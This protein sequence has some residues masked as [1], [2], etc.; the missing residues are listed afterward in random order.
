MSL[1]DRIARAFR[2]ELTTLG[3]LRAKAAP[4]YG[5]RGG[6]WLGWDPAPLPAS[7]A[8]V[9]TEYSSVVMACV[10]SITQV[11]AEA[12]VRVMRQT[13]RGVV[14]EMPGHALSALV[15]RPNPAFTSFEQWASLL[16]DYTLAG[17]A[18]LY[19][20]RNRYA[21]PVELWPLPTES[22]EAHWPKEGDPFISHYVF[23]SGSKRIRLAAEDVLHFRNAR[24]GL[25]WRA[26]REGRY[27]RS[28]LA[29]VLPDIAVDQAA[30]SAARIILSKGHPGIMLVPREPVT[31]DDPKKEAFYADYRRRYTGEG[32]GDPMLLHVPMDVKK[33]TFDMSDLAL[34]DVRRIAEERVS[35][36]LNVPPIIAGLGVGL[37]RGTYSNYEQALT[38]FWQMCLVPMQREIAAKLTSDLL[39]DLGRSGEFVEFDTTKIQALREDEHRLHERVRLDWR[40]DLL[41][42]NEARARL[43]LAGVD[44]GDRFY[45]ELRAGT[46]GAQPS[47][48]ALRLVAGLL[49]KQLPAA[50]IEDDAARAFV[51]GYLPARYRDVLEAEEVEGGVS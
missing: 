14:E 38:Q 32:L 4:Y 43:G 9:R 26:G 25:D 34:K 27:G 10:A 46:G 49:A 2:P 48:E 39:P 40:A 12:P 18:Y 29:D 19:K 13:A 23:T 45:S 44:D 17:N 42:Q 50:A 6:G 3:P 1:L 15:N 20:A 30:A 51:A 41:W 5:T 8:A 36:A 21:V 22:V 28:P 7:V 31:L 35:A 16:V 24:K 11:F 37:D 33:L 47:A